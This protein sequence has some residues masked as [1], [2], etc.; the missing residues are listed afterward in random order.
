MQQLSK[1]VG[2]LLP[3]FGD[4]PW[5]SNTIR[6]VWRQH[7][8]NWQLLVILDR[9][10]SSLRNHLETFGDMDGKLRVINSPKPGISHALNSGI[11]EADCD[12]LARIDADDWMEPDRL[13]RQVRFLDENP[14]VVCVGSQTRTV[15][16]EGR[17]IGTSQ[18]PATRD[19][20]RSIMSAFNVISHPST[21]IRASAL[22]E[23]GGYDSR[24]DGAEDYHLWLRLLKIGE[25]TNL[26]EALTNY[27]VHE[28]QVSRESSSTLGL[29]ECLVR[30][31]VEGGKVPEFST[32]ILTKIRDV[33]ALS[34][35]NDVVTL[36]KTVSPVPR[37]QL[38]FA[39][40]LGRAT[41]EKGLTKLKF[42]LSA[43]LLDPLRYIE[44][45]RL[46]W[47]LR[48]AKR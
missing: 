31:D 18:L 33:G 42:M 19:R 29:L 44:V 14:D 27:R 13:T 41:R 3:V 4:G 24:F 46:V 15:D 35:W 36:E 32:P 47:S 2:V 16:Q 30:L 12:F 20:V 23:V 40:R 10:S 1:K 7:W 21:M 28:G 34:F 45:S 8:D 9:P 26:E 25:I 43:F 5:I 22:R 39:R 38:V 37:R 17:P 48:L 11:A 6:S